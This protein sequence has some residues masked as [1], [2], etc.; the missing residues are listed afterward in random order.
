M[1]EA[2]VVVPV[3][4]PRLEG[5]ELKSLLQCIHILG[6][7]PIIIAAPV[8][9]DTGFY[10]QVSNH[11]IQVIRFAEKY[12][13]S[14]TGYSELLTS[15]HFYRSFISFKYILIYQVDAWVFRDELSYW[16]QQDYDYI[17]APWIEKPPITSGKKPLVDLSER[18]YNKV[19]NG[20]LSLRKV[21]THIRWSWLVGIIFKF[22]PKNEDILW[23]LFAPL[24]KPKALHALRFAYELNPE[25]S[26]E[27]TDKQL[28]FGCHAWEKYQNEFWKNFI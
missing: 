7:H 4:K 1:R 17:G 14:T 21:K 18:L 13:T 25:K 12:F 20:G 16:C 6:N 22:L 5:S 11:E 9:L 15:A 28:P 10:Q 2:V 27:L 26:Y 8:D 3:Y 24:K 23:T 19:G